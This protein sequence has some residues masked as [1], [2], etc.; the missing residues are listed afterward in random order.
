VV[1]RWINLKPI[2]LPGHDGRLRERP[3]T[4]LV[5]LAV[6]LADELQ[7]T[8]DMPFVLLGHSM[9]GWLAFEL[10]RV[11]RQRGARSPELLVVAASRAPQMPLAESPIHELPDREFLLALE[12]RYGGIAPEVSASP[13]LLQLLLP[14]L[15]A[16]MQ[17]VE[18]YRYAEEAPLKTEILALGGLDD[19]AVSSAQLNAWQR[20]TAAACS[21]RLLPGGH[22]F[23]FGSDRQT[24]AFDTTARSATPSAALQTII[25]RMERF[26]AQPPGNRL[27]P[28]G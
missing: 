22:F 14:A 10:S 2:S 12:R 4:D 28:E 23:L 15:R 19:A 18:T 8:L 26:R 7:S 16:D 1:P 6:L 25:A 17:M 5:T 9:G 20:Q 24:V 13:E 3:L 11:L 27:V 21:V